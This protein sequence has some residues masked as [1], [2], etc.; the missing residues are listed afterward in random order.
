MNHINRLIL[1]S[2]ILLLSACES[3]SERAIR[4]SENL[5]GSWINPEA[6][7]SVIR[8]DKSTTLKTGEYGFTFRTD[9]IFVERKNAGWCGTPPI[10]YA[11]F[12]GTWALNDSVIN[13]KVKYWGGTTTYRWKIIGLDAEKLIIYRL[14]EE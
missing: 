8:F 3:T 12:D 13:I 1:I 7:D 2:S 9:Q 6:I 4:G 5:I 14:T 10:A 11:D